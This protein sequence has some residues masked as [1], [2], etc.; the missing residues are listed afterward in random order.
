MTKPSAF[1]GEGTVLMTSL[2]GMAQAL[3]NTPPGELI[4]RV[5]GASEFISSDLESHG[6][7]VVAVIGDRHLAFWNG[8][9]HADEAFDAARSLLNAAGA[10]RALPFK[11]QVFLGTGPLGGDFFG[12]LKR[13]QIVGEAMA[14]ADR[15]S[16]MKN[17]EDSF[18]R[19]SQFTKRLLKAPPADSP[20]GTIK[21]QDL[22]PLEVFTV[23]AC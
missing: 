6:G 22:A 16:K 4:K 1:R 23:A 2:R 14:I 8:A 18:I 3:D 7:T 19:M 12:P 10:H 5:K 15:I 20:T 13:Y 9:S 11:I 17:G 21:R